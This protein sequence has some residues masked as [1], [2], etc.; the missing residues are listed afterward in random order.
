MLFKSELKRRRYVFSKVL[1]LFYSKN[2]FQKYFI[3]IRGCFINSKD[4]IVIV[5]DQRGME[6]WLANSS[7]AQKQNK[8]SERVSTDHSRSTRSRRHGLKAVSTEPVCNVGR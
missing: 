3:T 4:L 2:N 5:F 1:D 7:E 8:I 6:G